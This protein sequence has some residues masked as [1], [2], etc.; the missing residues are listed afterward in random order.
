MSSKNK[1]TNFVNK[2][3][4][5]KKTNELDFLSNLKGEATLLKKIDRNLKKMK[6]N[7]L[8]Y[9]FFSSLSSGFLSSC[10]SFNFV[11]L[12]DS[13]MFGLAALIIPLIFYL[14]FSFEDFSDK[15]YK[16]EIKRIN[17][18]ELT[19]LF[20]VS[21]FYKKTELNKIIN[22]C[23]N[24]SYYAKEILKTRSESFAMESRVVI[25]SEMLFDSYIEK[26]KDIS[27]LEILEEVLES[28]KKHLNQPDLGFDNFFEKITT[29]YL[30][31]LTEE[32]MFKEKNKI[33]FLIKEN[34]R[35]IAIKERLVEEIDLLIKE[36]NREKNLEKKM[37][38]IENLNIK[39]S[40]IINNS[41]IKSI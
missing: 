33:M 25:L 18:L 31:R 17:N 26:E 34:V 4:N 14:M 29:N 38:K 23:E 3:N 7:E 10:I 41:L 19:G 16:N 9:V 13:L 21:N 5:S 40:T 11:S 22:D 1:I 28:R 15:L 36:F 24:L 12:F 20:S 6:N 2:V 37:T 27:N 32:D 39:E 30:K 8:K 35:D